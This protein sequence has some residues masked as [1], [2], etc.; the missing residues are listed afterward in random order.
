MLSWVHDAAA[1]HSPILRIK[2]AEPESGKSTT[3]SLI[4]FLM[5]RCIASVEISEA[6]I[7]RSIKRWQPSFC[8]DEFDTVMADKSKESLRAVI[9]S[10]HTPGVGVV[11][12]DGDDK[13]PEMFSTFAA[14]AI[15]MIGER[16][17]PATRSR[18]IDV[19]LRRRRKG[20]TIERFKFGDDTEL[21]DLR[22]R[23]RRW[24]MDSED[25]L[26]DAVPTTPDELQNRRADN[27]RLQLAIADLC[28]GVEDFG[29]KARTAAVAIEGKTDSR[30]WGVRLL[31]DIK[32]LFDN[33]ETKPECLHS[34]F[35]VSKLTGDEEKGWAEFNRGRPLTQNRLARLLG[36]YS[37]V[38]GNV[39]SGDREAKGYRKSQFEEAWA[40]YLS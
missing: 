23:L 15:G 35:I 6:A 3:M 26:R 2:S 16:L 5:P 28:S 21:A 1:T 37:I 25:A 24:A 14:K 31:T 30:T 17:P 7:F 22:R 11:R 10:G 19:E 27:W 32:E 34:S 13:T 39:T 4:A 20:E 29:D 33:P 8:I 38:S 18:C 36:A 12:C 40:T 9:N